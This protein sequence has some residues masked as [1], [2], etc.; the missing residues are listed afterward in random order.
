MT[1]G[2]SLRASELSFIICKMEVK[3]KKKPFL[4]TAVRINNNIQKRADPV[5][6]RE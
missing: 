5:P 6:G 2:K 1:L 3:K 4:Q